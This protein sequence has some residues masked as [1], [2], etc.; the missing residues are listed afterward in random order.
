MHALAPLQPPTLGLTADLNLGMLTPYFR[1]MAGRKDGGRGCG[2]SPESRQH[3]ALHRM[4]N[5]AHAEGSS[6]QCQPLLLLCSSS[7]QHHT[8]KQSS[9]CWGGPPVLRGGSPEL[10]SSWSWEEA[11]K[12]HCHTDSSGGSHCG[13]PSDV[14]RCPNGCQSLVL[15]ARAWQ[16]HVLGWELVCGGDTLLPLRKERGGRSKTQLE[17]TKKKGKE[18]EGRREGEKERG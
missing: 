8:V 13:W 10:M 6:M 7:S 17:K 3:R 5:A 15:T 9:Q 14:G 18:K 12:C 11:A 16:D 1:R 2:H 4:G